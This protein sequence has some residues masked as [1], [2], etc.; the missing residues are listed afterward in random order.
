MEIVIE[1]LKMRGAKPTKAWNGKEAVEHFKNSPVGY[2]DC[3]LMDMY[4]PVM[5][6]CDAARQIRQLDREDSNAVPILAVT[7]N[8]FAEDIDKTTAA[9]MNGHI[10]KPLDFTALYKL[11]KKEVKK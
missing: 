2:Y 5:D 4:M 3:I 10:S 8:A 9:G 1:L 11:M 7:A 6:G